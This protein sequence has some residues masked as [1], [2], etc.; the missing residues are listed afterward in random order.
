M[1]LDG[2]WPVFGV[3]CL[4]G[5]AVEAYKWFQL[6]ETLNFPVYASRP[7]YWFITVFMILIGGAIA[8]LYGVDKVNAV[9]AANIGASAPAIIR[10]LGASPPAETQR[11]AGRTPRIEPVP[12]PHTGPGEQLPKSPPSGE[13][14]ASLRGFLRG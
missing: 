11:R 4:G 8:I 3:A 10:A 1:D 13:G 14:S 7:F 9:L 6:R 5:L 2:F 12:A